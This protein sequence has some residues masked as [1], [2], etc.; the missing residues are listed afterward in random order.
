MVTMTMEQAE[1]FFKKYNGLAFHMGR[2]EEYNYQLY[3]RLHVPKETEERWRAELR[4]E[5]KA[6]QEAG[7]QG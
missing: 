2:E 7:P 1:A 4:A 5:R 6:A 3:R